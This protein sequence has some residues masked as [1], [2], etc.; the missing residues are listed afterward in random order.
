[1]KKQSVYEVLS[2][3]GIESISL[4]KFMRRNPCHIDK[5]SSEQLNQ[6]D[7]N[8]IYYL[9]EN[10]SSSV[11]IVFNNWKGERD[12]KFYYSLVKQEYSFSRDHIR[13]IITDIL[14]N[15]N[16]RDVFIYLTL[17]LKNHNNN[18]LAYNLLI[19]P[20]NSLNLFQN[21]I[22]QYVIDGIIEN[23]TYDELLYGLSSKVSQEIIDLVLKPVNLNRFIGNSNSHLYLHEDILAKLDLSKLDQYDDKKRIV[24][25][26]INSLDNENAYEKLKS[27]EKYVPDLISYII[28]NVQYKYAEYYFDKVHNITKSNMSLNNL[29]NLSYDDL[30]L[31]IY[32]TLREQV[33]SF[34]LSKEF[35]DKTTMDNKL[36]LC[37][38]DIYC[39]DGLIIEYFFDKCGNNL[40]HLINIR[41]LLYLISLHNNLEK[42]IKTFTDSNLIYIIN[43]SYRTLEDKSTAF[44]LN[45]L[46]SRDV[47]LY[48]KLELKKYLGVKV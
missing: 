38:I 17:A 27:L 1:M 4:D 5:I 19:N 11:S 42:Y 40:E 31:V 46:L 36:Y 14:A 41:K 28:D 8:T 13:E 44:L 18:S 25:L 24:N 21:L 45:E 16:A 10:N 43:E 29:L 22:D 23:N 47:K 9:M 15:D 2:S 7:I 12:G 32:S 33:L 6:L 48:E 30:I 3:Y 34:V 37:I 20:E 26:Y 35:I 39:K